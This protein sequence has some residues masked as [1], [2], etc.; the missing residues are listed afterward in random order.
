MSRSGG[1]IA[2][3]GAVPFGMV[4]ALRAACQTYRRAA[5]AAP[6]ADRGAVFQAARGAK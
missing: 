2:G 6:A 3:D 5:R 1:T 4:G